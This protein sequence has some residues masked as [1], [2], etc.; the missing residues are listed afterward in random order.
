MNQLTELIPAGISAL[1]LTLLRQT[2]AL[3]EASKQRG[4][5]PFAALVADRNGKVIVEAGNNSMPPELSLIHI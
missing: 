3:S 1:D 2:I 5:H 4:R